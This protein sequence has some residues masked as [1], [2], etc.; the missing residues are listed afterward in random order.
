MA[1]EAAVETN[2]LEK[3]RGYVNQVRK[4]KH[5][6]NSSSEVVMLLTM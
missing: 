2:A 1:A 5:V 4:K 3:G 6:Q